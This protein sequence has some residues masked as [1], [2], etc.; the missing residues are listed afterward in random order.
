MIGGFT[1][2]VL[3]GKTDLIV[4]GADALLNLEHQVDLLR[5]ARESTQAA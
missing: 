1:D 5:L 4:G 2:A 3:N